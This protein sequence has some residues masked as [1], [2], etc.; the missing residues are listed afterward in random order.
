MNEGETYDIP[1]DEIS[2]IQTDASENESSEIED[3][4]NETEP[5]SDDIEESTMDEGET[6]DIHMTK[7]YPK[8]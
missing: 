2:D 7:K 1:H 5:V 3:L 4:M 8:V 6:Y